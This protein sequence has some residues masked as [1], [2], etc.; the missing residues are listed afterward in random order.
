M[1][2]QRISIGVRWLAPVLARLGA[3]WLAA[4]SL[5]ALCAAQE[6]PPV[7]PPPGEPLGKPAGWTA[8]DA[9]AL[10]D[11]AAG[12]ELHLE[13]GRGSQVLTLLPEVKLPLLDSRGSWIQVRYGDRVGWVDLEAPPAPVPMLTP[14]EAEPVQPTRPESE[15]LSFGPLWTEYDLGPYQLFSRVREQMM[16]DFLGN[17]AAEHARVY[18]E[19]YGLTDA[20]TGGTVV[21]FGDRQGFVEFQ[22]NRGHDAFEARID[23]YFHSPDTVVMYRGHSSRQQLAATLIH[24]LT[25]LISWQTLRKWGRVQTSMPPWLDEGMAED[26][27]LSRVDRKG[28]LVAGP[29]G[30]TN[31]HYQRRLG[32][33]LLELEKQISIG[34]TAP[35]LPQ[36]LAMDKDA[37]L[38]SDSE[39]NYLLSAL[40]VRYLLDDA[41]LAA[42]FRGFLASVAD[43]GQPDAEELRSRLG[44]SWDRLSQGFRGWLLIQ[45]ARFGL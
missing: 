21:L 22:R 20:E 9:T 28:R 33:I 13:P 40:W 31:L 41:K 2:V 29:L 4:L 8:E 16:V 38:S 42:G 12:S 15:P 11:V 24:E 23:G 43:G 10:I 7:R 18:A 37:F 36:L 26:L 44:H 27:A 39:L 6:G 14:R 17:V 32:V 19:R 3:V 30:P 45:Q 35:S 1:I 34:G 25:H 5:P